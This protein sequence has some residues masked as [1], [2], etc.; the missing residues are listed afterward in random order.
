LGDFHGKPRADPGSGDDTPSRESRHGSGFVS[1]FASVL[2]IL[3]GVA[4]AG[5]GVCYMGLM[6]T[7]VDASVPLIFMAGLSMIAGGAI[8]LSEIVRARRARHRR[9]G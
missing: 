8:W 2:L 3:F 4:L 5:P 6:R 1:R 7:K 9:Q